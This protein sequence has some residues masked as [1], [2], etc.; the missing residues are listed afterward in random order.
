MSDI[1]IISQD[2][3]TTADLF[4]AINQS[5]ILLKKK[6]YQLSGASQISDTEVRQAKNSLSRTVHELVARLKLPDNEEP[7]DD[8]LPSIPAFLVARLQ[9]QHRGDLQWY[10]DDLQRLREALDYERPL[11]EEQIRLLDELC[12]QLDAER[13]A[14]HRKLWRK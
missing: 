11:T 8:E 6:F 2:Y 14:L 13:T 7:D 9:E 4:R 5:V 10:L 1:G 12:E 3:Q